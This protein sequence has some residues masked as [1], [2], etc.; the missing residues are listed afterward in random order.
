MT[1]NSDEAGPRCEKVSAEGKRAMT[2]EPEGGMAGN[3]SATIHTADHGVVRVITLNI[4]E[5]RNALDLA[6][7]LALLD[8]LRAAEADARPAVLTG[9]GGFF[10]AGGDIRTMS[11][12]PVEAGKRLDALGAVATQLVHSTVPIVAAVEG[13]AY[14]AG[15]SL[16][17][18]ATYVVSA[19]TARFEASFAKIGLGPDAGLS[20]TLPR[21][22]G[23]SKAR[24]MMLTLLTMD[25]PNAHDAGLV[26][27]VVGDGNARARAIQVATQLA[28]LPRQAI[29]GVAR[30]ISEDHS[31]IGAATAAEAR[32]QIALL[33]TP[34]SIALR[35]RFIQRPKP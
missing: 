10:S 8:A 2:G 24:Q 33:G 11:D 14:G 34:E 26:D 7:R 25:A 23:R 28:E 15:L 35:E 19:E 9:A 3:R 31:S 12:D 21:R 13:G 29:V 22:I 16:V 20:W 18:A 1:Q 17:S 27:E 5:R 4:P 30:L 6:A 32:L